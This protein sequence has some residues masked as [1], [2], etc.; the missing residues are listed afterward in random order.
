MKQGYLVKMTSL[1]AAGLMA[2]C[3][4]FGSMSSAQARD[5]EI[6]EGQFLASQVTRSARMVLRET[7]RDLRLNRYSIYVVQSIE[8]FTGDAIR[9]EDLIRSRWNSPWET[10]AS[11]NR[12]QQAFSNA[13]ES[14]RP[15]FHNL[16]WASQDAWRDAFVAMEN[17]RDY[18]W[19]SNRFGND[20]WREPGRDWPPRRG[21]ELPPR[22]P[23][24]GE[25]WGRPGPGDGHWGRPG[26]GGGRAPEDIPG[27][28]GSGSG[29]GREWGN[30][31][32]GRGPGPGRGRDWT[33]RDERG[34]GDRI[35][36]R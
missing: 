35:I 29:N 5:W 20:R 1:G 33:E 26:R 25:D 19:Y 9:F 30:H 21:G 16:S 7:Q 3:V 12:L 22:P 4:Q 11:F 23:R 6:R 28:N 24:R 36:L 8:L 2:L 17:L 32:P 18:Y 13:N 15:Y 10:E 14:L 34:A 27:G 31:E